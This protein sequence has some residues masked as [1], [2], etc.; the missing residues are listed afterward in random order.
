MCC[1]VEVA[2]RSCAA[3]HI[4]FSCGPAA[5]LATP[6]HWEVTNTRRVQLLKP[7]NMN[8]MKRITQ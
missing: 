2:A 7:E 4:F 5:G 3:S 8:S 6:E 1:Y